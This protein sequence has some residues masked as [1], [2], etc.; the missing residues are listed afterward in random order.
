M[1]IRWGREA[2]S[3]PRDQ[4]FLLK[5]TESNAQQKTWFDQNWEGDQGPT[6]QCVGYAWAHWLDAEP[7][8][9]FAKPDGIYSLAQFVDEWEGTDYEGTSV[10]AGAK[11]LQSLGFIG[12]YQWAFSVD[13]VVQAI[14]QQ[15]P[16]VVGT[17][18]LQ[19]MMKPDKSGMIRAK[20]KSLGGHAYVLT[21][22]DRGKG[23][24]KMK[25][26][27]GVSWGIRGRAYLPIEDFA[28]LLDREGEACLGVETA[29][30]APKSKRNRKSSKTTLG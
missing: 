28:I 17:D 11:V 30:V 14:L 24:F 6:P 18:W 13:Q 5:L 20:G 22:V 15:G 2:A 3:D 8:R 23:V 26:S 16:V 1:K 29:A 19:G 4:R 27:W 10:R 12:N 9:Q 21:G 7:I 25:Q